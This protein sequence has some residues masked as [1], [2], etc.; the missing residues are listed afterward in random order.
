MPSEIESRAGELVECRGSTGNGTKRLGGLAAVF[1]S[2]S[3]LLPGGFHEIVSPGAFA[4]SKAAGWPGVLAKFEHRDVLGSIRGNTLA[5]EIT[6]AGLDYVVDVVPSGIGEHA[7]ALAQRGDLA[8]SFAFNVLDDWFELGSDGIPLRHL[9]SLKLLD[10]SCV[11]HPAYEDATCAMRRLGEQVGA[12][13]RRRAE[14]CRKW[15]SGS[16]FHPHRPPEPSRQ[17]SA[18]LPS[19]RGRTYGDA[20][21]HTVNATARGRRKDGHLTPHQKVIETYAM[22]PAW[23]E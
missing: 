21:G 4:Q 13:F 3:Q 20:L 1:G 23:L 17:A 10:V 22:D 19:A 6:R 9:E 2:L 12:P 5:L 7:Y 14:S 11:A 15:S 18:D 8:S 16:V